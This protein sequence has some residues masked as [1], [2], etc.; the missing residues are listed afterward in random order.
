MCTLTI[1]STLLGNDHTF[2]TKPHQ[3]ET[4]CYISILNSKNRQQKNIPCLTIHYQGPLQYNKPRDL[5]IKLLT[6]SYY[7]EEIRVYA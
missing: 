7:P 5:L 6:S 3:T 2:Q 1:S 4:K